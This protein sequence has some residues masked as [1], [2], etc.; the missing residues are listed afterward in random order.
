MIDTVAPAVTNKIVGENA[1]CM[2][3][4]RRRY[5]RQGQ[6]LVQ[7]GHLKIIIE[8]CDADAAFWSSSTWPLYWDSSFSR[9]R[10]TTSSPPLAWETW[11][12]FLSLKEFQYLTMWFFPFARW[13]IIWFLRSETT[14]YRI[15]DSISHSAGPLVCRSVTFFIERWFYF[16]YF[17][18]QRKRLMLLFILV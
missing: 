15:R 16:R 13:T 7:T 3:E 6:A 9:R 4:N 5:H 1:T 11:R 12:P 14:K 8:I 18:A 2:T 10:L 17:P